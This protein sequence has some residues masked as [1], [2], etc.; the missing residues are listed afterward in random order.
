MIHVNVCTKF[1]TGVPFKDRTEEACTITMQIKAVYSRNERDL[2]QLVFNWEPRII[3]LEYTLLDNGIELKW[4]AEG[5]KVELA[6]VSIRLDK[7]RKQEQLRLAFKQSLVIYH[8]ISLIWI[9]V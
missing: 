8:Q 2:K 7:G 3:P 6:E 9:C 1:I 5:Q 4:K